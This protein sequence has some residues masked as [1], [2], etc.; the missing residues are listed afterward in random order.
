MLNLR[1]N[2]SFPKNA[3]QSGQLTVLTMSDSG[4]SLCAARFCFYDIKKV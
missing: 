2:T 1:Y 3:N 4:L